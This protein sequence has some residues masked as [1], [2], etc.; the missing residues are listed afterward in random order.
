MIAP[1]EL[2]REARR[3]LRKLT[4]ARAHLTRLADGIFAVARNDATAHLSRVR[5]RAALTE[6]F[7]AQGWIAP[8]APGRFVIT[9]AGRLWLTRALGG[10]SGFA[11]QHRVLE[12]RAVEDG[13][14]IKQP[15]S[16]NVG[17]S[18]L[19]RLRYRGLVAPVQFEA[20]ERLRRDF[21]LAQMTPRLGMDWSAPCVSGRRAG[22]AGENLSDTVIAA[23]QRFNR[24]LAAVGPGLSD[25]LFDVCCHLTALESAE[26]QRSWARRSG[27]VVL[28]IALDRLADH[29][30]LAMRVSRAPMRSWQME[31]EAEAETLE[32]AL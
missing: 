7:A 14:G 22:G 24:A 13:Q 16:V 18:P 19:A 3:V 17:E 21:T 2:E 12:R 32:V 10:E 23:K 20:G 11:D 26:T 5:V 29:Y 27:R 6:A 31:T 4:V 30:G 15:V 8:D 28:G 25:L 1:A 9:D